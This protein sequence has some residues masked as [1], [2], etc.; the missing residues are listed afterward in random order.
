M[1]KR[2]IA[3]D[4]LEVLG[5]LIKDK[6]VGR[7]AIHLAC[8]PAT[9]TET[10]SPG[11]HVGLRGGVASR[12]LLPHVGIVDPFLMDRVW[13]GDRFLVVVYPRTI[14]SLRHVWTHPDI[15]DDGALVYLPATPLTSDAKDRLR[16]IAEELIGAGGDSYSLLVE[17]MDDG[18]IQDGRRFE[19]WENVRVPHEAWGLFEKIHGRPA[20]QSPDDEI[21][22]GC[23]C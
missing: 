1:D 10:L 12:D 4:A 9:C 3:T 6:E 14:E 2:P 21:Y 18:Y 19:G 8:L 16:R 13:P 5:T 20:K 15:P 17:G 23:S 22:F 7:D 11:S